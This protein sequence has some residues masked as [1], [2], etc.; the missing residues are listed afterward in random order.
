MKVKVLISGRPEDIRL[1]K[2]K[3]YNEKCIFV[4]KS[5]ECHLIFLASSKFDFKSAFEKINEKY[6][7]IN[8]VR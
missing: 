1:I 2:V 6:K 3:L 8:N 5:S 4:D 7:Q